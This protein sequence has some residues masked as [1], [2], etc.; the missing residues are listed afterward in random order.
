M[1]SPG[2]RIDLL[3]TFI[4]IAE[5]GGIGAAARSLNTSQPTVSRRL[6]QLEGLIGAKL[7]QRDTQSLNLTP[8]GAR[9]LPTAREMTARWNGLSRI[10]DDTDGEIMGLVRYA[11]AAT[12]GDS[13]LNDLLAAF[14]IQFPDV[15]LSGRV[16]D[17]PLDLAAEDLD[18]ALYTGKPPSGASGVSTREIYNAPK[19][20][21]AA[22]RLAERLEI[23]LGVDIEYCE[24]LA[25]DGAPMVAMGALREESLHFTGRREETVDVVFD[26]V[27][28]FDTHGPALRL[29]SLGVGLALLPSWLAA[30]YLRD[31]RLLRVAAEW[32]AE[33][34]PVT[35]AWSSRRFHS[36][37]ASNLLAI[38]QEEGPS[39]LSG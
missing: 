29:A 20:L 35:L 1:S 37:A 15:Q 13:A 34:E 6:Q 28:A 16:I 19:I 18:F 22:P 14:L 39:L 7:V 11:A 17:G 33:A 23:R 31:G 38:I 12:L 30:P 26:M 9:L 27:A 25:L 5:T 36:A 8:A 24:P 32:S 10:T 2:D 3:E 4:R 21:C